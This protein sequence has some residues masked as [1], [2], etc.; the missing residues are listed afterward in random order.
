VA[1]LF[2]AYPGSQDEKKSIKQLKGFYRVHLEAGQTKQILL[3]LRIND[4]RF[5]DTGTNTWK[6]EPGAV[7]IMVGSSADNI[8]LTDQVTIN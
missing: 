8:L 2:I 6:T 5:F 7:E 4:L 3:P 1:F